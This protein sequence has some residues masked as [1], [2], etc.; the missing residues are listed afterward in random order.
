MVRTRARR[1]IRFA[2]KTPDVV[3][4]KPLGWQAQKSATT[5]TQILEAAI[6]CFTKLGYART[7]TTRIAE[8]AGLSRGAML[9][10]FPS[11]LDI[12][13]AA[14][15]YL[16]DKRLRAFRKAV[17]QIPDDVDR[18]KMA[19]ESY[20]KQVTHPMFAAFHE[21][22]V[23]AR[24]DP[25]LEAI[26]RPAQQAFDHEFYKTARE[27]FPEWQSDP[28]AFDLALDLTQYLLEGMAVSLLLHEPDERI[29]RLLE[30][31]EDQLRALRPS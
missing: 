17:Q 16:H 29:A 10:H 21:L 24:T 25:E 8:Q 30:F 31:L 28:E 11:K 15:D 26:L 2:D 19:V 9:H 7:T 18:I 4:N 5:R 20:W 1:G 14:V 12:V 23:A 13:R 6:T 27:V 22:A 3:E